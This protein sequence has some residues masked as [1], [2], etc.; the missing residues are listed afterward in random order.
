MEGT[1]RQTA[2]AVIEFE[3]ELTTTLVSHYVETGQKY[4]WASVAKE[5]GMLSYDFA[6]QLRRAEMH[7]EVYIKK[8]QGDWKVC[9][10]RQVVKQVG[11][12]DKSTVFR[13]A[14]IEEGKENPRPA[15]L[16]RISMKILLQ[17]GRGPRSAVDMASD[18][19]IPVKDLCARLQMLKKHQYVRKE[20]MYW[21]NTA[22]GDCLASQE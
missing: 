11:E 7:G 2:R 10:T 6:A 5:D 1:V 21:K 4:V 16:S 20:L 12:I 18:L 9:L 15:R 14:C 3:S 13:N 22:V 17:L 19:R 8:I